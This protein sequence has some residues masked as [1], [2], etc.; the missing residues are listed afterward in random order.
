MSTQDWTA[1]PCA[2]HTTHIH[3]QVLRAIAVLAAAVL[4]SACSTEPRS[5]SAGPDPSDPRVRVPQAAYRS[6]IEPYESL[7][8]VDPAPW[9][10]QNQQVTPPAKR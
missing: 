9:T 5:P 7:R 8:P 1:A 6:T 2:R 4:A 3:A 10:Q